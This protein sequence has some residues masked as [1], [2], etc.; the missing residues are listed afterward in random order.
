M[1]VEM[2]SVSWI[3]QKQPPVVLAGLLVLGACGAPATFQFSGPPGKSDAAIQADAEAC[4][5]MVSDMRSRDPYSNLRPYFVQCMTARGDTVQYAD[6][7]ASSPTQNS[8]GGPASSGQASLSPGVFESYVR[9]LEAAVQQDAEAW[10]TKKYDRGSLTNFHFES[11]KFYPYTNAFAP[12]SHFN[13]DYT[14]DGGQK[15]T[16]VA[17]LSGLNVICISNS[18]DTF[19]G[20][21]GFPEYPSCHHVPTA[22]VARL[23]IGVRR[24]RAVE[25]A[26]DNA[27]TERDAQRLADSWKAHPQGSGSG[28]DRYKSNCTVADWALAPKALGGMVA[29][30]Y[31]GGGCK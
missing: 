19:G 28:S 6:G 15:G 27:E 24:Q 7:K 14:F 3:W 29:G 26:K 11:T 21:A 9:T 20:Y 22:E 30:M 5:R 16:V 23:A 17:T 25:I 12:S 18:Q 10:I 4:N 31:L 8:A 2:L 13:A 1:G